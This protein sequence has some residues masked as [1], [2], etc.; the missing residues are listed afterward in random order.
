MGCATGKEKSQS[1][2][3][4]PGGGK[5]RLLYFEGGYARADPIR[6]LLYHADID[7]VDQSISTEA[8]ASRKKTENLAGEFG[9]LPILT[10]KG[11]QMG[12]AMAILRSLGIKHGYYFPT[13][14]KSAYYS[15]VIVDCWA[16]VFESMGKLLFLMQ[17]APE[18]ETRA[19]VDKA[20]DSVHEPMLQLIEKQLDDL[21]GP[22]I[23][24]EKLTIA[25]F[26]CAAAF[27]NIWCNP[28]GPLKEVFGQ[29]VARYP[30]S[31]AYKDRLGEMFKARL[32]ARAPLPF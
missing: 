1:Q 15:D 17:S 3:A 23:V 20:V 22:Y 16:D 21:G 29:V 31:S 11:K 14:W 8:W 2:G 5:L 27:F 4:A 7:F 19:A 24:G 6:F 10:S 18:A 32:E 26:C 12:Q 9:D 28:A 30:K 25:D 13:D